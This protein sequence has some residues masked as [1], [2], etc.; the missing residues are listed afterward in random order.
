[1]ET[2]EGDACPSQ[3]ARGVT[4]LQM[5]GH[6]RSKVR[7]GFS[8]GDATMTA[9]KKHCHLP[10]SLGERKEF[11]L[12]PSGEWR[13]Y[14]ILLRIS[15]PL[16][17]ST[18]MS[19]P[20]CGDPLVLLELH[21]TSWWSLQSP[22]KGFKVCTQLCLEYCLHLLFAKSH[23]E[24]GPSQIYSAVVFSLYGHSSQAS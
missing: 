14:T 11:L 1:M 8:P 5:F 4:P 15:I 16:S 2:A 9:G 6:L 20:C 19:H 21:S 7:A 23:R 13:R 22:R 12:G 18:S 24:S 3:V 10:R 17:S